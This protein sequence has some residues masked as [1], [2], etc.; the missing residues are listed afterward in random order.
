MRMGVFLIGI[1]I[2]KK[3]SALPG[4]EPMTYQVTVY[5]ADDKAMCRRASVSQNVLQND[6]L[7]DTGVSKIV[8]TRLFLSDA[9]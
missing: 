1:Q 5:E 6:I 7:I 4:F 2:R 8:L 3:Y 9:K